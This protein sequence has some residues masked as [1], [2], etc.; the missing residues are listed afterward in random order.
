MSSLFDF[1]SHIRKLT[2]EK[3]YQ[4][5]LSYFKA[6]KNQFNDTAIASN[7]Y[8]VSDL[9]SCLRRLNYFEAGFTFLQIYNIQ[10][11]SDT[12]E[13][14][15]TAYGWILWSKYKSENSN[16]NNAE[17]FNYRFEDEEEFVPDDNIHYERFSDTSEE[18]TVFK[19]LI[20]KAIKKGFN[21]H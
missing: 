14:I 17:E 20:F 1:S 18:L 10:I 9:L 5:A 3:K 8:L 19:I 6:N 11:N 15:L 13:R 21:L 12:K 2:S 16:Q 4:D 7:E